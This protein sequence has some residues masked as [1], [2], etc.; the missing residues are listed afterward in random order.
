MDSNVILNEDPDRLGTKIDGKH[1]DFSNSDAVSFCFKKGK[2]YLGYKVTHPEIIIDNDELLKMAYTNA[3]LRRFFTKNG[4]PISK[5]KLINDLTMDW[6]AVEAIRKFF[7]YAGRLW[8]KSKVISFWEFPEKNEFLRLIAELNSELKG[9]KIDKTW[10]VEV[11]NDKDQD[12]LIP[13]TKYDGERLSSKKKFDMSKLHTMS[14]KDKKKALLDL[15]VKSGE[16]KVNLP[17]GMTMAQFKNL[18][19]QEGFNFEKYYKLMKDA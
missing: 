4:K 1:P 18:T 16:S 8:T 12:V 7:D 3:K 10:K 15:G 6:N 2:A 19:R 5:N 11:I 17:S 13:I 14:P 9:V